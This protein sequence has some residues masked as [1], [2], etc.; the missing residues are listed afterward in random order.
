[1]TKINSLWH[2]SCCHQGSSRSNVLG[3]ANINLAD[4]SDALKPST[5]ALPVHGCNSGTILHVRLSEI[6]V[7]LLFSE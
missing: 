3:E 4:H 7:C 6:Y 5:V 1:M 2:Q